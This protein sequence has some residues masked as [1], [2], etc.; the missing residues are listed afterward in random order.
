MMQKLF[1]SMILLF[2]SL[3]L[4]EELSVE[5]KTA[6]NKQIEIIKSWTSDKQLI[7]IVKKANTENK[8]QDMTQEKWEKLNIL[9]PFVRD[10]NKNEAGLLLKKYK[11]ELV[12]EAFLNRADGKKIGFLAKTSNWSHKGKDK[13]E[14]P[15]K[16]KVWIGKIE[17]DESSGKTQIQ[18]GVPVQ[19]EGKSIG[20][21]VIGLNINELK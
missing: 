9:D 20:S 4:G 16:G 15:M 6:L 3:T 5:K 12:S 7:D 10:F 2:S 8:F 18:V 21:L 14:D 1:L 11:S 13:H 19:D 17:V